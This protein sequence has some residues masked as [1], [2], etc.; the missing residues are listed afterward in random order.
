MKAVKLVSATDFIN[1]QNNGINEIS[2]ERGNSYFAGQKQ[3]I[4]FARIFAQNPSIF[5]LDEATSTLIQTREE[6]IQKNQQIKYLLKTSIFIAHRL[7]TI[8]NVDKIIV[9][10]EGKILEQGNHSELLQKDGYY[11][12]SI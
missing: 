1:S 8:V 3:L 11:A 5:I 10:N 12:V 6:L 4:A 9:S 2:A 7:F